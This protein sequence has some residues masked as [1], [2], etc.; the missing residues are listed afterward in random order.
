MRALFLAVALVAA[1]LAPA[2]AQTPGA[3]VVPAGWGV[4]VRVDKLV[5][6]QEFERGQTFPIVLNRDLSVGGVVLLPAGTPGVGEVIHVDPAGDQARPGE[7]LIAVRYL[8]YQGRRVPLKG[9]QLAVKGMETVQHNGFGTLFIGYQAIVPPTRLIEAELAEPLDLGR[10]LGVTVSPPEP[11]ERLTR[12]LPGGLAPPP[13]GKARV[14]FFRPS[15]GLS[16]M[17]G[18]KIRLGPEKGR[19]LGTSINGEWFTVTLDPGRYEFTGT[20]ERR[21]SLFVELEPGETYFV[22]AKVLTGLWAGHPNLF[23]AERAVFAANVEK[24]KRRRAAGE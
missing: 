22:Q 14:V 12:P 15:V 21:D 19:E 9:G 23:P 1:G 11:P 5:N 2:M 4:E 3:T 13:P 6:S 20:Q 16:I 18:F 8:T 10:D 17:T 7:L 24:M